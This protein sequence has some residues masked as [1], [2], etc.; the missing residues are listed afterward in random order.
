MESSLLGV[1]VIAILVFCALGVVM[2]ALRPTAFG[3]FIREFGNKKATSDEETHAQMQFVNWK[4]GFF[5]L[6]F[7]LSI[8]LG[9]FAGLRADSV[10]GSFAVFFIFY[11][12]TWSVYFAI[13]FVIQG[14]AD[15]RD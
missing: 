6:T 13:G 1:L 7:V 3:L 9:T 10:V 4:K 14:F 5:R 12:V 8:F 2:I 11:A 15:K